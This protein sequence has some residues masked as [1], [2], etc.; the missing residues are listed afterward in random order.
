MAG[1][2][3]TGVLGVSE[4]RALWQSARSRLERNGRTITSS[5][6]QL[7]DLSDADVSSVC[8]LLS[9]R[10]P[11]TNTVRVSLA[12]LD[13]ALRASGVGLG[14]IDALEATGGPIIDRRARRTEDRGRV[15]D[16]WM[17]A[18]AHPAAR[19]DEVTQWLAS[20]RRRGRLT[21]LGADDPAALLTAALNLIHRLT[22]DGR[23]AS[24]GPRP[25]AAIAADTL[26]DAHALDPE[27]PLGA[28]V[29]D[30]VLA[31]SGSTDLRAAWR[32]FGVDLDNISAS[33]LCFM[34]PGKVGSVLD[35]GCA[36]AEPLRITGRMLDRGLG[37]DVQP[38]EI[39]S[40]CENPSIVMMAADRL[41]SACRPLVCLEG[42]PSAVTGRLLGELTRRGA[43]LRV[44]T[45]FDFGG[46]SI[47]NH[48]INRYGA[49]SWLM[50]TDDYVAAIQRRSIG[51]E[52]TVGA[53]PWDP[54]LSST[55]NTHR[56]AV[57]EE[58]IEDV[59]IDSLS[60]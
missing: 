7:H 42:M 55:M 36:T 14:L 5:P 59:L 2:E 35:A 41:D 25:L 52:R 46:I 40:I 23:A 15:A 17:A 26:G 16:L 19:S 24:G 49:T 27:T 6:I 4:L 48:V 34:L 60:R 50:S 39:V 56:R 22:T 10:R 33:A 54:D 45:D 44:H 29:V 53:T 38:G 18:N 9:R 58:V 47:M 1:D 31:L 3:T 51:L 32:T 43:R 28:L 21:R 8:A 11:P 30:A 20:V 13:A 37:L 57:H 12:D